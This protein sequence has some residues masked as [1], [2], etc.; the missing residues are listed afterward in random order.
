VVPLLIRI[1]PAKRIPEKRKNVRKTIRKRPADLEKV[2][3]FSM[4][5]C[6]LMVYCSEDNKGN[7]INYLYNRP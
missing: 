6:K 5:L 4:R 1:S 3:F 2:E 7:K